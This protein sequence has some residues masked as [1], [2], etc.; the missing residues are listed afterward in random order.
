MLVYIY[1]EIKY[2]PVNKTT[3]DSSSF[4]TWHQF[5]HIKGSCNAIVSSYKFAL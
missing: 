3:G 4:T 5:T 1:T 2:L